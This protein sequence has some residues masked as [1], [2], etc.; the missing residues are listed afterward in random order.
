MPCGMFQFIWDGLTGRNDSTSADGAV[1]ILNRPD[2]GDDARGHGRGWQIA[3]P[4]AVSHFPAEIEVGN[5]QRCRGDKVFQFLAEAERQP[6]EPS[7]TDRFTHS[8]VRALE[9]DQSS[10][11]AMIFL[12]TRIVM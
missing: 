8:M 1:Q 11:A 7:L 4:L 12:A 5:V 9:V 10:G 2:F 6:R 3:R